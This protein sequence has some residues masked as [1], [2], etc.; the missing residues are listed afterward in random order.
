MTQTSP[1]T[2]S[3]VVNT[4]NE[5]RRLARCLGSVRPWVDEI[6]VVD[7]DSED[8]T[9]EIARSFGARVHRHDRLAYADPAR[10]YALAQ[11]T[12]D[13]VLVL[14]ADEMVPAA[15]ARRLVEIATNA[16]ADVV[17][18]PMI[19]YLFGAA[20]LGT[21]W[22][23]E[24]DRHLRFF[25]RGAVRATGEIHNYLHVVD[26]ARVAELPA[27]AGRCLVHHN[28]SDVHQFVE[29]MNRYT[30][31]EAGDLASQGARISRVAAI[32]WAAR[33]FVG[34]YV[35]HRGFRDGW[36]GFYL[37]WLMAGYR[38]VTAAKLEQLRRAGLGEEID[39]GYGRDADRLLAEYEDWGSG[40]LP[41][42]VATESHD[43]AT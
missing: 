10:A 1:V 5:E 16:E 37:A 30:D 39:A 22:G 13:W 34:R 15:L 36:R 7:M 27:I 3:A 42:P 19:N 2:I 20:L 21:G 43:G 28:Y 25:R 41:R 33:A 24:Q 31:I 38:L 4:L 26:G 9:A 32:G 11:A 23:P 40:R 35:R 12:G 14:D 18:I 29:K 17:K 8:R 6:V